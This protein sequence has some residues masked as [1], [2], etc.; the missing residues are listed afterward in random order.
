M[1][2]LYIEREPAVNDYLGTYLDPNTSRHLIYPP[3]SSIPTKLKI[4]AWLNNALNIVQLRAN[5]KIVANELRHLLNIAEY[6]E[7]EN[8]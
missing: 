3:F 5:V 8:L 1:K 4:E 7:L 6:H 2:R